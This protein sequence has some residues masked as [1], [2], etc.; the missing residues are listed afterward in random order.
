MRWAQCVR[1]AALLSVLCTSPAWPALSQSPAQA[2]LPALPVLS[3]DSFPTA[4]R[5]AIA[6]AQREAIARPDDAAAVGRLAMVLHAWEQWQAAALVYERARTLAPKSPEWPYLAAVVALRMGRAA[7]AAAGLDAVVKMA[8]ANLSARMKLAEAL[9]NAGQLAR[10]AEVY[11]ALAR[12]PAGQPEAEYGLGRIAAMQGRLDRRDRAS[13][14]RLRAVSGIRR[15][16][17]RARARLPQC[18][19][20]GRSAARAGASSALRST[21]AGDRRSAAGQGLRAEG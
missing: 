10:S 14:A 11:Q 19:P 6:G 18:R 17:L 20:A 21:V 9:L 8:P 5:D 16:A 15:G 12:E 4:A 7:D 1:S 13:P 2:Q 3:L